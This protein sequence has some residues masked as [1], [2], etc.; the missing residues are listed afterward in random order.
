MFPGRSYKMAARKKSTGKNFF[1]LYAE[2]VEQA[3]V[4]ISQTESEVKD[5]LK[6]IKRAEDEVNKLLGKRADLYAKIQEAVSYRQEVADRVPEIEVDEIELPLG[7]IIDPLAEYPS[8]ST[9]SHDGTDAVQQEDTQDEAVRKDV[10][11]SDGVDDDPTVEDAGAESHGEDDGDQ[12]DGEDA[13]DHDASDGNDEEASVDADSN[14]DTDDKEP[15]GKDSGDEDTNDGSEDEDLDE[16]TNDGSEDEDLAEDADQTDGVDTDDGGS[17]DGD[18]E[19]TKPSKRGSRRA[20]SKSKRKDEADDDGDGEP[21]DV[22]G[23][24]D[25]VEEVGAEVPSDDD[26]VDGYLPVGGD[27]GTKDAT[28]ATNDPASGEE[29]GETPDDRFM[30]DGGD[31]GSD[32]DEG[33]GDGDLDVDDQS[34][35][36]G[37]P[38]GRDVDMP[39]SGE[40]TIIIGS[41]EPYTEDEMDFGLI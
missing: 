28:A 14:S 39:A 9:E 31:D 10:E 29:G 6:E 33:L 18:K 7:A 19:D 13:A 38:E 3:K 5:G 12:T 16:K 21:G 26:A 4:E 8:A 17:G 11:E 37:A 15:T 22:D 2:M 40:P 23:I 24:L 20:A 1:D 25:A 27:A 30:D 35:E 32:V 34:G 36:A 41:E